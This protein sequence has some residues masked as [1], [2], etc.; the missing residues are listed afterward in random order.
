[1]TDLLSFLG[2][3]WPR[4][5]LYPGGLFALA[6]LW[7]VRRVWPYTPVAAPPT[8]RVAEG[9]PPL[10]LLC[11]LP[12]PGAAVLPRAIDLPAALALLEWPLALALLTGEM[13]DDPRTMAARYAPLLLAACALV[14][15][16]HSLALDAF[17]REPPPGVLPRAL[18]AAGAAYWALALPA[19]LGLG[20]LVAAPPTRSWGAAMRIVGHGL[21]AALLWFALLPSP[22]LAPLPAI[23]VFLL[24]FLADRSGPHCRGAWRFAKWLSAIII[25]ALIV[26]AAIAALRDRLV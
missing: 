15:G 23:L 19:L 26:A 10:L 22:W 25:G 2:L 16:S 12:L 5:L 13:R 3:A 20:P 8:L 9:V 4:L 21:L 6:L 24:L 14:L 18:L 7:L 17:V 11:L 1:M